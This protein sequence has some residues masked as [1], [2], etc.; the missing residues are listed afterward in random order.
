MDHK[1]LCEH[2]RIRLIAAAIGHQQC[3]KTAANVIPL[4]GTERF[5]TIGTPAEVRALLPKPEFPPELKAA[6]D[7]A[8]KTRATG[9]VLPDGS[10]VFINYGHQPEDTEH[11]NCTACGGS[12]HIDDQ[13]AQLT[14][15][16]EDVAALFGACGFEIRSTDPA[17][18]HPLAVCGSLDAAGLLF[19]TVLMDEQTSAT[20]D[21]LAERSRQVESEGMTNEGDDRYD[22]AELPRAAASYIL[23]GA[24]DEAPGIWPWAKSW[25]KPRD[26]RANYVRAA[27]LLLAEIER[28]DRAQEGGAV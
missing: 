28:I 5:I 8:A 20:R 4:P 7:E 13:L 24:N 18:K 23:N 16:P 27:A 10:A 1:D 6:L 15:L 25:W 9:A 19:E 2:T 3:T 12:G 22:A 14:T 26:A 17:E 11:L 21:V